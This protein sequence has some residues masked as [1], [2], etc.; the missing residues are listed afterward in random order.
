MT[1]RSL[2]SLLPLLNLAEKA[3]AAGS[4]KARLK[5][6]EIFQVPVNRRGGW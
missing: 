1:R 6:I 3:R 2:L 4:P 5:D